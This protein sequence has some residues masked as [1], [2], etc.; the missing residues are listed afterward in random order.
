MTQQGAGQ[1]ARIFQDGRNNTAGILQGPS[2]TNATA[3]IEQTGNGNSFFITENQAG[4]YMRVVQTGS[5]NISTTQASGPGA[6][7]SGSGSIQPPL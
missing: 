4:Q 7:G 2:A 5:N 6:G 3:I 1:F